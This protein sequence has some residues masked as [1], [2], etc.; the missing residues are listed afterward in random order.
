MYIQRNFLFERF[1]ERTAVSEHRESFIIKGG[2]LIT[3]IVGIDIRATRDLD[4]TIKGRDFSQED[5]TKLVNDIIAV[6]LDDNTEFKFIGVE[7]TRVESDYP[8]W[9]VHLGVT[10][11][12]IRDTLKLDI[13]VGDVI[14]PRAIEYDY[15]LMVNGF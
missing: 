10:F 14:T 5:I 13:T 7:R 11:D 4:A 8:G 9:R 2:M 12:K 15:K 1:L 3:S 6:K